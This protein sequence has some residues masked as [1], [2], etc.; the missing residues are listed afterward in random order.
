[1]DDIDIRFFLAFL[2]PSLGF[3]VWFGKR[4]M[5]DRREQARLR[6]AQDNLV[7]ALYAEID[8]NT[9]DM[10]IFL[11]KSPSQSIL[12]EKLAA[13]CN[14]VPHIT[15]ARHTE[16]YR[17][18]INEV[19]S[20]S[21]G[22]LQLTVHFYGL[23]EKIRVQID[24]INLPSYRTLSLEGR[25]NAVDVIRRTAKEAELCGDLLLRK[26][27]HDHPKLDLSRFERPSDLPASDDLS[28][29][30]IALQAR[31]EVFRIKLSGR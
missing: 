7:R 16:I 18:K 15:D 20:I 4:W 5:E 19:H 21:D 11:R 3:A 29:R 8:F 6:L 14:L 2:A 13:D 22:S 27:E 10:D 12:R 30:M 23:L 17:N 24:G 25:L 26:L 31:I 1:V 28:D 9:Y